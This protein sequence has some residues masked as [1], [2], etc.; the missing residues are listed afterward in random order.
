MAWPR[1][2][3]CA[4]L[5]P[6]R[7]PHT[8]RKKAGRR[9]RDSQHAGCGEGVPA[10]PRAGPLG[11]ADSGGGRRRRSQVDPPGGVRR[12][13]SRLKSDEHPEL[14]RLRL[15]GQQHLHARQCRL[16]SKVHAPLGRAARLGRV[17][18]VPVAGPDDEAAA[19]P[20]AADRNGQQDAEREPGAVWL[21]LQAG[22]RRRA[23]EDGE[24]RVPALLAVPADEG[25]LGGRVPPATA[26]PPSASRTARRSTRYRRS[27]F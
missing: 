17:P 10:R 6:P 3:L 25:G 14:G 7:S 27:T 23:H 4:A 12:H 9:R 21:V 26:R 24:A 22:R 11:G 15:P 8:P 1:R 20:A 13:G 18:R 5:S 16:P 19:D 2:A